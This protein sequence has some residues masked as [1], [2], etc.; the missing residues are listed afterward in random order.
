LNVDHL[1]AVGQEEWNRLVDSS[2]DVWLWHT[3]SWVESVARL[4][5]LETHYFVANWNGQNVGGF[6]LQIPR[7]RWPAKARPVRRGWAGPF[8]SR[9]LPPEMRFRIFSELTNTALKWARQKRNIYSLSCTIPTLAENRLRDARAT[10]PLTSFGW[11]DVSTHV[12]IANLAK[13]ENELWASL[14]YDAR[15]Q[16]R[17]AEHAGYTVLKADWREMAEEYYSVHVETYRRSHIEPDPRALL[18]VFTDMADK[19]KAILL[20]GFDPTRRPVAF[21]N[22]QRFRD[23]SDYYSGCCRTEHLRAGISYLLFWR[24]MMSAKQD[25]YKWYEIG[26]VFPD[27]ISGKRKGLT[28]FKEKFDGELYRLCR[29]EIS[30]FSWPPLYLR[31]AERML[32]ASVRRFVRKNMGWVVH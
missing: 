4:D 30:L 3:W 9:G 32:P 23:G 15:R 21:H 20:A 13:P 10:N 16:I 11:R 7:D 6:T 19:G 27:A 31:M 29:G 17:G 18:G 12:R 2:D 1:T 28:V 25:G 5:S 8:C 26:E 14:S 24:A 22:S